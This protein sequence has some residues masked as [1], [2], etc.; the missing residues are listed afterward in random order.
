M[1]K[2]GSTSVN[3]NMDKAVTENPPT[4]KAKKAAAGAGVGSEA[5]VSALPS[6][7]LVRFTNKDGEETGSAVDVPFESTPKQLEMLINSLLGNTESVRCALPNC[8]VPM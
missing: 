8:F 5:A 3:N 2:R 7:V 6:S 4:K 1:E